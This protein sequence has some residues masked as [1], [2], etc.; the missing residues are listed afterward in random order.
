MW[1]VVLGFTVLFV[2]FLFVPRY[3][4]IPVKLIQILVGM[5]PVKSPKKIFA[6]TP[7]D[8]SRCP[9]IDPNFYKTKIIGSAPLGASM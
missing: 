9:K 6:Q 2:L 7:F 4:R 5:A 8:F 1:I 3:S